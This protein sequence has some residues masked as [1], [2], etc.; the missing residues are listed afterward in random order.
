MLLVALLAWIVIATIVVACC[1]AAAIGDRTSVE[2]P[3]AADRLR[4]AA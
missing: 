3:A 1:R 2:P 4:R